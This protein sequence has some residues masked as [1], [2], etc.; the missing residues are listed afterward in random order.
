MIVKIYKLVTIIAMSSTLHYLNNYPDSYQEARDSFMSATDKFFRARLHHEQAEN[1]LDILDKNADERDRGDALFFLME[2]QRNLDEVM[3]ELELSRAKF[4]RFIGS[5]SSSP[6]LEACDHYLMLSKKEALDYSQEVRD[7]FMAASS[8]MSLAQFQMEKAEEAF[9]DLL[10][11][12]AD[13][14]QQIDAYCNLAYSSD[15]LKKAT[16]EYELAREKHRLLSLIE[17]RD[18]WLPRH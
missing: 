1:R 11:T 16:K 5:N 3:I 10:E 2:S 13:Q 6:Y 9:H 14:D 8:K 17:A 12:D 4:N 18:K 15:L 7:S